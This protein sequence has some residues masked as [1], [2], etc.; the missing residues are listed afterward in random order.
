MNVR[1]INTVS[2][3]IAH[4]EHRQMIIIMGPSAHLFIYYI[5]FWY[6]FTE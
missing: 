2:K 6:T 5:C 3:Q 4:G 1:K